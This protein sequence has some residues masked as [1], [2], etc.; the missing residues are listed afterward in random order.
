MADLGAFPWIARIGYSGMR[1]SR[2]LG[3]YTIDKEV[4]ETWHCRRSRFEKF[5]LGSDNKC[6]PFR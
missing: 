1:S 3:L 6:C 5:T 4:E 2:K